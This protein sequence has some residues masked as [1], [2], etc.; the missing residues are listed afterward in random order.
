MGRNFRDITTSGRNP[1]TNSESRLDEATV[2]QLR[3]VG[4]ERAQE[5]TK[6]GYDL[7]KQHGLQKNPAE[8][9]RILTGGIKAFIDPRNL[10][11]SLCGTG[12][13]A[14]QGSYPAPMSE[15][16]VLCPLPAEVMLRGL[17][18]SEISQGMADGSGMN[19]LASRGDIAVFR[20]FTKEI[21]L[22]HMMDPVVGYGAYLRACGV[23]GPFYIVALP[24]RF[25]VAQVDAMVIP[26]G[27]E[28]RSVFVDATFQ[29]NLMNGKFMQA[30]DEGRISDA[31]GMLHTLYHKLSKYGNLPPEERT[32]KRSTS[33]CEVL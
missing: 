8:I 18:T 17:M 25:G 10:I 29:R 13:S 5:I 24:E 3:R 30:I 23:K 6:V 11:H 22:G 19:L 28:E 33:H 32:F 4:I 27:N 9:G 14:E 16:E 1:Y 21:E 12:A 20:N 7:G 26:L 31:K 2:Q 15:Y